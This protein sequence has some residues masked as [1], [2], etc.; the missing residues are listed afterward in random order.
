[1]RFSD[2][3]DQDFIPILT[4]E[5]E[6][7]INDSPLPDSLP[8][9][10]LRNTVLFPG[11]VIPISVG[12]D[13][14]IRLIK[15]ATKAETVIG[16]IS[17]KEDDT[18]VPGPEDLNAVGTVARI[19][20]M[21][22]MP[23]GTNTVILQGQQRFK[24]TTI[25]QEEPYL[26]ATVEAYGGIEE[27][28]PE[29]ESKAMVE[30]L[31]DLAVEIIELSPNIPTE[32]AEAIRGIDRLGFLVNFIGSNMQVGVEDKQGLLVEVGL[33]ERAQKVLELLHR[34][35]QMRSLTCSRP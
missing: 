6:A 15:D 24:W 16:V 7:A 11:V 32:A 4:E 30:S 9:L 21:L 17:Q 12:R 31:R 33:R 1:M 14:S 3:Q 34:E 13:R 27:P 25:T 23:D 5:D 19:L 2:T 8:L 29:E 10:S 35:K 28:L 26:K 22:K 20:K 18:E